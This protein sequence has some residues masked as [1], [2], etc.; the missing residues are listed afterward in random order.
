MVAHLLG[1]NLLGYAAIH[2]IKTTRPSLLEH[3]DI[4]PIGYAQVVPF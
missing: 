4:F 1:L 2:E 3:A